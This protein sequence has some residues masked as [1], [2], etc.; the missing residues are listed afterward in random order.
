MAKEITIYDIAAALQLSPATVSRGLNDHPA[1]NSLTKQAI[2]AKAN[3]LGYR[4]NKFASNLRKQKTNTIGVIVPRLNSYLMST[5]LAG[6]EKVANEEGFNLLISQSLE[7]QKK[8]VT[9]ALTMFNSRVDG[10][11]VS[12]AYDTDSFEHFELF[13]HKKIPLIFFD[14]VVEHNLCTSIVIDNAKA[15]YE[16][17]QHLIQQGRTQILH[18]TGSLKRNVYADRL[19]GYQLAL[20]DAGI[21][22]N[23]DLVVV[24]DLSIESGRVLAQRIKTQM[25]RSDGIFITNDL[26]A[27]SC[28]SAL[29]ELGISVPE[30]ISVVG[31]NNDP[32]AQV[33]SPALTTIHYP[34]R[35]MG[36]IAAKSMINHLN[37]NLTIDATNTIVLK[38]ELM[39]RNS[40]VVI[41]EKIDRLAR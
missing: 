3:E 9:N 34:G 38:S 5:V 17:T 1:I 19:K 30:D 29:Q 31:F 24:S 12:V 14:R 26:C 32:V 39:V 13:I 22:Y 16:A 28:I 18:V 6:M 15:G 33:I 36:E 37:G 8:E 27:V 25:P 23:P 10:L 20:L 11:L 4:F 41:T 7:L 2:Q 21:A 35:E 40:S